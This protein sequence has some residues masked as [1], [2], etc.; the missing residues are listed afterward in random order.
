MQ[1][2]T[3]LYGHVVH[4]TWRTRICWLDPYTCLKQGRIWIPF[5]VNT[6]WCSHAQHV[7]THLLFAYILVPFILN[8]KSF[9]FT[10][11]VSTKKND[12]IS[13]FFQ[14]NLWGS[15]SKCIMPDKSHNQPFLCFPFLHFKFLICSLNICWHTMRIWCA[16]I[17]K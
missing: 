4:P 14:Q 11:C 15:F 9:S 6:S 3:Y 5:L 7:C 17:C 1:A 8:P 13:Q 12:R 10:L 2:F 16:D